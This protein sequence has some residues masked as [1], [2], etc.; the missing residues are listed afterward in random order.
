MTN[1]KNKFFTHESIF[2]R[3][4][5][6][7]NELEIIKNINNLK[8]L[9]SKDNTD[10]RIFLS[11][12]D[13]RQLLAFVQN[14]NTNTFYIADYYIFKINNSSLDLYA[15]NFNHPEPISKVFIDINDLTYL[16]N[17]INFELENLYEYFI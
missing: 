8:I 14:R 7:K 13:S 16:D 10:C 5:E 2:I 9:S 1:N 6:N 12:Y 17:K 15:G 11:T 4:L 3:Q